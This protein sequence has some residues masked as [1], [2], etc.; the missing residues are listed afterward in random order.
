MQLKE[1]DLHLL[2]RAATYYRNHVIGHED[3]VDDMDEALVNLKNYLDN[4]SVE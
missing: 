4:Y 2:L 3:L 1:Q